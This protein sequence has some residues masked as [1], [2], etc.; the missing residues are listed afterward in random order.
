MKPSPSPPGHTETV[1]ADSILVLAPHYDDEVLGCGGLLAERVEQGAVA[2]V[3]FLSD[4]AAGESS[5]R[6]GGRRAEAKAAAEVLGLAGYDE[7]LLPDGR[8]AEHLDEI[9]EGIRRALLSQRPELVLVPS[10]LEASLDHRAAFA[11]LHRL[12][13]PVRGGDPLGAVLDGLQILTYEIN[14][15]QYADLLVDVGPRVDTLRRAMA[16]YASQQERHDYLGARLGLSRYRA[17]TLVPEVEAVE[18]YRRLAPA[19][20][21][22]RGPSRLIEHLGGAPRVLGLGDALESGPTVSVIV[23]TKNR[24]ELLAQAL[25]SL[26]ASTYR[27]LEILVVNDGGDPPE[28]PDLPFETR[29][30]DL[31][32][33]RGRAGAANAGLAA[34]AGDYVAFLDDDDLVEPEH[35]AVLVALAGA[36]G[37]RVAYTDAAV[38][39]YELDGD[40]GWRETARRLP[41]SRDFDPDLLLADNYIPFHTLLIERSLAQEVGELDPELPIFEDWDFLIRLAVRSPFH[42][43][44]RVTCEYRQFRG[45]GHHVLGDR[46]R[47]RVDF[48]EMKT[49]VLERHRERLEPARLARLV[50]TLR[51]ETVAAEEE[52]AHG[53]RRAE[54]L[55]GSYHALN[56]ELDAERGHRRQLEALERR[57]RED[58]GVTTGRL[59]QQ[60]RELEEVRSLQERQSAQLEQ[61]YA[62]IRRLNGLVESM[63]STRAWRAHRW[64]QRL[65][66]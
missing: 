25:G 20:F 49:R 12:L 38:G 29:L 17:L 46:P 2:R 44:P 51:A 8:L 33:G 54:A 45:A 62:E 48:L 7:L 59:E 52:V 37:V 47:E 43:L 31:Q 41:Y 13:L 10:P 39:V 55:E 5:D 61:A 14:H 65:K 26:G 64:L 28:L 50:D 66:S 35:Y 1:A 19:D 27:R 22:T 9:A 16:C 34:A 18:G 24:P 3:L 53:R 56:G 36:E 40:E 42:H 57:T 30:V 23:R 60:V 58:L 4:G 6:Q 63:E 15:P 11:A 21:T 32:P